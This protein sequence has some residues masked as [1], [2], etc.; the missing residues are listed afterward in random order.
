[1]LILDRGQGGEI[2]IYRGGSVAVL[3]T[4]LGDHDEI[5]SILNKSGNLAGGFALGLTEKGVIE[6]IQI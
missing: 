4:C 2:E 5:M 3:S 1:M 6:S